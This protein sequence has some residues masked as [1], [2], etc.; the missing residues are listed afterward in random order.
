MRRDDQAPFRKALDNGG[1]SSINR[2]AQQGS[3]TVDDPVT[4]LNRNYVDGPGEQE[5]QNPAKDLDPTEVR[6]IEHLVVA[7]RRDRARRDKFLPGSLF[8]DPAWDMLLELYYAELRH[9]KVSVSNLCLASQVPATTA[10]RWIKALEGQDL[11]QRREDHLDAR[12]Y[13]LSLSKGGSSAMWRYF[14]ACLAD[15][16][17]AMN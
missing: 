13:Y 7:M 6:R 2:G 12:R 17:R 3:G 16:Q 9:Y 1:P 14:I 5:L 8:A 11:V 10:L 15:S 4:W